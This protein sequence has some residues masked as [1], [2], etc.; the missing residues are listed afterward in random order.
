[1]QPDQP[2]Q[3]NPTPPS[4]VSRRT[5]RIISKKRYTLNHMGLVILTLILG[6]VVVFGLVALILYLVTAA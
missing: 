4:E 5:G 3:P 2:E 6:A 1:M